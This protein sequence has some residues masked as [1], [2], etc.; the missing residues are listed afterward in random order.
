MSSIRVLYILCRY[1]GLA[2][3]VANMGLVYRMSSLSS[4]PPSTCRLWLSF[5]I[6][7]TYILLNLMGAVLMARIHAFY[8]RSRRMAVLLSIIF[9]ARFSLAISM[10]VIYVPSMEF[11]GNCEFRTP[12]PVTFFF[13]VPEMISQ[14]LILGLTF[15]KQ[16]LWSSE[17]RKLRA[18]VVSLL[19]RDGLVTYVAVLAGLVAIV[20]YAGAGSS[21]ESKHFVFPT[22]L[23][24]LSTSAC[25]IIINLH[26]LS[27]RIQSSE[28]FE[29]TSILEL[30]EQTEHSVEVCE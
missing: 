6:S 2:A 15:A 27:T 13:L 4:L 22:F 10:A 18:P 23:S 12:K 24:I 5:Q 28:P 29:F 3:Q 8:H 20:I 19:Y 14:S 1:F 21:R 11:N 25:R 9:V 16:T 17:A 26:R 7:T 30:E